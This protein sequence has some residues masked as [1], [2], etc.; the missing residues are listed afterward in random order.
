MLSSHVRLMATEL[1][2]TDTE[3]LCH[4]TVMYWTGLSYKLFAKHN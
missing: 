1:H 2:S 3:L 4:C